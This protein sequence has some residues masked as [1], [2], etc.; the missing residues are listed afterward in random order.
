MMFRFLFIIS[1]I[2]PSINNL[3]YDT[4]DLLILVHVKIPYDVDFCNMTQSI[5]T[6]TV[7]FLL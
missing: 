5:F 6:S 1:Q 7:I 4:S 2:F 3:S